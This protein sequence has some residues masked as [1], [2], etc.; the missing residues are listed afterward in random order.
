MNR[1]HYQSYQCVYGRLGMCSKGEKHCEVVEVVKCNTLRW[2][3]HSERMDE[4][5]MTRKI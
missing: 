3:S 2:I 1:M 4:N 5:E